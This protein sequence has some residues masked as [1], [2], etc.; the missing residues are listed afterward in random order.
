MPCPYVE[1]TGFDADLDGEER[2]I[3]ESVHRFS[4]EKSC[5]P[6]GIEL[7][8][9]SGSGHYRA[10][11]PVV[12]GLSPRSRNSV[13]IRTRSMRWSRPPRRGSV[14]F[15]FEELGWGDAGLALSLAVAGLSGT[16][17]GGRRQSRISVEL[18][19]G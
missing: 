17:R 8:R 6:T 2:A 9:M 3:I 19:E 11:L 16:G 7:D 10:D 15:I 18:C 14:R 4:R 1:R 12:D 5:D 13:S